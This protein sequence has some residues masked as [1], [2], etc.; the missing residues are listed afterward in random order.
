MKGAF[1]GAIVSLIVMSYIVLMAQYYKM[2]GGI[3]HQA[4]PVSTETCDIDSAFS[5]QSSK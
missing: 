2:V 5:S 3:H 4:K 1:W